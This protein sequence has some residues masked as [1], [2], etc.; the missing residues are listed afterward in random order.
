MTGKRDKVTLL[1]IDRTKESLNQ[2]IYPEDAPVKESRLSYNFM[3]KS[4]VILTL[5]Y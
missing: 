3:F 2:T 4:K 5:P 1:L